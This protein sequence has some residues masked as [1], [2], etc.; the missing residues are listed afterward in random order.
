MPRSDDPQPDVDEA[1]DPRAP[2]DRVRVRRLP[3]LAAYD[4]GTIDA[5]LDAGLVAHLGILHDDQPLVIPTLQARV[6]DLL[7]VH[8][9]AASRTLRAF[10]SEVPIC[11][12]VTLLDGIV[13]ARSIFEH[14]IAY[15]SVVVVGRARLVDDPQ[16]KLAALHAFSEQILRG[17]WD[18]V[19]QPNDKELKATSILAL[20][21]DEASAKV[22]DGYPDDPPQDRQLDVWAGVLPLRVE[23]GEPLPDVDLPPGMPVPAYLSDYRRDG[24]TTPPR[25]G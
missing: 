18:D 11:V 1:A 3:E 21:L 25:I 19:R 23:P 8:G 13:L 9:S 22:N 20:P 12:T 5:I 7:Y 16:E 4:R 24:L 6:G 15:R 2:S 10:A 14:S 17:R